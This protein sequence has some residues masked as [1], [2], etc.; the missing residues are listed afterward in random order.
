MLIL[1]ALGVV[2]DTR[3]QSGGQQANKALHRTILEQKLL[4][5][6]PMD[7]YM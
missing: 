7:R 1:L 5:N 6:L 4:A 3:I 2:A